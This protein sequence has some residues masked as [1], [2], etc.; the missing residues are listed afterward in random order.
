[1]WFQHQLTEELLVVEC[2]RFEIDIAEI[3][4]QCGV[5]SEFEFIGVME[6]AFRFEGSYL[7]KCVGMFTAL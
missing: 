1:M 7:K 3:E 4:L 2:G 6:N 5:V